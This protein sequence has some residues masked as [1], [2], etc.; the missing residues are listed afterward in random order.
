VRDFCKV[1]RIRNRVLF[2]KVP[3]V[4][5]IEILDEKKGREDAEKRKGVARKKLKERSGT[6][7]DQR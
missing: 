1:E 3:A 4:G 6:L 5:P 7:M 2:E